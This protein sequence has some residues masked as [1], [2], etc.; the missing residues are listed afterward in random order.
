MKEKEEAWRKRERSQLDF[1]L[2][3]A[4]PAGDPQPGHRSNWAGLGPRCALKARQEPAPPL[5]AGPQRDQRLS[6]ASY[7]W[8]PG[9]ETRVCMHSY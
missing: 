5:Q 8:H 2:G 1:P 6:R 9:L 4:G 7:N 3:L